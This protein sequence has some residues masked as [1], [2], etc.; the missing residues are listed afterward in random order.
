MDITA[1]PKPLH[2]H[3]C[4]ACT[5]LGHHEHRVDLYHCLQMGSVPTVV[6]RYS[7]QEGDYV[8]GLLNADGVPELGAA[9]DLA[10]ARGLP[11][12]RQERA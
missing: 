5:F 7:S 2:T 11:L 3:D 10:K 9:R 8:S 12:K 4:P 1:H 6:A